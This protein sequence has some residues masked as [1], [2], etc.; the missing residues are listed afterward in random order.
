MR[1]YYVV[2]PRRWPST[3]LHFSACRRRPDRM[4][5]CGGRSADEFGARRVSKAFPL[6]SVPRHAT[7]TDHSLSPS[8]CCRFKGISRP[9][10]CG[11][12]LVEPD[13]FWEWATCAKKASGIIVP[14]CFYGCRVSAP[15]RESLRARRGSRSA[16]S[17]TTVAT[18]L[19]QDAHEERHVKPPS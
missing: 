18:H 15:L 16:S 14:R 1:V 2:V 7:L 19:P 9:E 3:C 4:S 8:E 17:T 13:Y 11:C 5:T 6:K 10:T 12:K